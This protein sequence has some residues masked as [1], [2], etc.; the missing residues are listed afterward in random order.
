[1][2]IRQVFGAAALLTMLGMEPPSV[3]ATVPGPFRFTVVKPTDHPRF[4][5]VVRLGRHKRILVQRW[6]GIRL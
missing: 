5:K 6:R 1:M 3:E 4:I 2:I